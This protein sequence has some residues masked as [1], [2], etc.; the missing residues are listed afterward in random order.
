MAHL[1]RLVESS[2]RLGPRLG[3]VRFIYT[4]LD[5]TLL[6]PGGSIFTAP[7]GSLTLEPARA[8]LAALEAGL[9]LIP[10]SGR[11]K[12]QLLDDVRMLGLRDYI[13]EA[14][15]LIVHDRLSSEIPVIDEFPPGEGTIFERIEGSGAVEL[16]AEAFPGMIEAHVPW[17]GNREYSHLLRGKVG[18]AEANELLSSLTLPI[19]LIDNGVIRPREH[20]LDPSIGEIHAYHL[21]PAGSSKARALLKDLEMRGAGREEAVAI[22]DSLS[23]LE[24]SETV[25][26]FFLVSNGARDGAIAEAAKSLTNVYVS[27]RE[28]GLGWAEVVLAIVAAK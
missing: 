9:N 19:R 4:D 8:L 25:G 3:R 20:G 1:Q 21:M 24:L 22:G 10:I 6:G 14:G 17:T 13:A 28:M 12:W 23:D 5:G 18:V 26:T 7:D 27:E 2:Q 11:N 15:C 16:L